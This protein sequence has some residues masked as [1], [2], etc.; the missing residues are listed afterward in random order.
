MLKNEFKN[1]VALLTGAASGIGLATAQAFAEAGAAVAITDIN[2]NAAQDAAHALQQQGFRALGIRCDVTDEASVAA[3][4]QATVAEFG[5][6]DFAYNNAGIHVPSVETADARAEDFD[7][8]IAVNLKGVWL[9]MKHQLRHMREQGYGAI[10]NC[11]SQSG[12][13]GIAG[14][15]AYTASKHG[16]IGLT[17]AAALEYARQ[18]IRINAICPGTTNTPMVAAAMQSHPESMQAVIDEIPAGRM[19]KPEE[20][21]SAVLWLCSAGAGF[22]VG[23]IVAP[24]GGY[25]IR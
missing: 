14:L 12:L 6:L 17:K 1:K 2:E 3:A 21:A 16:V 24:D 5:G 20:I 15:G 10:V 11:S 4:V 23:Q 19:G 8:V 22:M 9:C 7:R 18:G 25:V 13:V